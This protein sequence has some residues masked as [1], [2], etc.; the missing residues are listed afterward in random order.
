MLALIA[1]ILVFG[2][3]IFVH[4]LGHFMAAK[5]T[6]VYAPRFSIGFGPA[7]FRK[8][9][10]ETEYVIAALPLGGYVRMASRHDAEAAV[11]EGGNEDSSALRP[12]D[13]GYDPEAMKPFGPKEIPEHRWF[14]SKTLAQRLFIM[15]A[16]VVMNVILA[17]V[18]FVTLNATY[19]DQIIPSRVIGAVRVPPGAPALA[20]L[21]P[22]DTIA[23]VNGEPVQNWNEI[24]Q[25]IAETSGDVVAVRTQRAEVRVPVSGAGAPS[26]TDIMSSIDFF[27]PPV[28]GDVLPNSPASRAG[29][30]ARDSVV[31]IGGQPLR[32]WSELQERVGA[33]A[34]KSIPFEVMRDGRLVSL[35]LRPES[36]LV[37]DPVT[38][39]SRTVGK[40]GAVGADVTARA[41][42]TLGK[43]VSA[44]ARQ[45]W[46]TATKIVDVVKGLLTGGVS[47]R[48]LGGPIAITRASVAAAQS[49]L[50]SLFGL[51][52][53]LSV[54]VAV[55]NLLPIPILDG[56]QILINIAEAAKGSPFS[57][58]TRE[59]ILRFGLV[60]IL[61][62]F[63]LSTFN[64]V[65][66]S[67]S[68]WLS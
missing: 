6:G 67:L 11:L 18:V 14:E 48:Q 35:T 22:G 38:K 68:R 10:G 51:I 37:K 26:P 53:L 28:I 44:G 55:L 41:P 15:I 56:G 25:R 1:P 66:D 29:L 19:G 7:L 62:I 5:L 17:F 52:A 54:N 16:G 64:D 65:K 43:S 60:A 21:Q 12:D 32:R 23:A 61:L 34:G 20:Q 63:A 36:T 57:S 39:E 45:T 47:P 9:R 31:S 33:S 58:R 24:A 3:V 40:I 42:M 46:M 30:R 13:A 50:E 27:I 49:G 8:R 2:L 4:E 59:Y